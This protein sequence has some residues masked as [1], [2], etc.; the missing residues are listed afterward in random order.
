MSCHFLLSF[1]RS[2]HTLVCVRAPLLYNK[3]T[4]T[5]PYI[6]TE[7]TTLRVIDTKIHIIDVRAA[8]SRGCHRVQKFRP[9]QPQQFSTTRI[10]QRIRN[11][12]FVR[13]TRTRPP[14]QPS[15]WR[16][17]SLT[18]TITM[19]RQGHTLPGPGGGSTPHRIQQRPQICTTIRLTPTI[20]PCTRRT[21]I[22]CRSSITFRPPL[23]SY[24]IV[25]LAVVLVVR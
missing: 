4:T 10:R 3:K 6:A 16:A 17:P 21:P 18:P 24:S 20:T 19:S 13:E 7:T 25:P 15:H 1:L 23:P 22:T 5:T 11:R 8:W 9:Y 12:Q 14:A 2:T